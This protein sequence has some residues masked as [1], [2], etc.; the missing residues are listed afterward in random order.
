MKNKIKTKQNKTKPI[1]NRRPLLVS[2]IP[3]S[4]HICRLSTISTSTST[5]TPLPSL[6]FESKKLYFGLEEADKGR[7][8]RYEKT[9]DRKKGRVREL[10]P[11]SFLEYI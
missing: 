10:F 9:Q 1:R 4:V 11:L 5:S 8:K 7:E 6:S 2:P 3:F